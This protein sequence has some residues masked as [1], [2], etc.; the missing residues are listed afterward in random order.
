MCR[1]LACEMLSIQVFYE[2]ALRRGR[3]QKGEMESNLNKLVK[4]TFSL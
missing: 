4:G 2:E 3:F 1:V